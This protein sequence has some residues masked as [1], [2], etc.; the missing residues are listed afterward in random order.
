MIDDGAPAKTLKYGYRRGLVLGLTI[1]EMFLLI[2]FALLLALAAWS[3]E[4]KKRESIIQEA[5]AL[6]KLSTED[7]EKMLERAANAEQVERESE[8]LRIE[9]REFQNLRHSIEKIEDADDFLELVES[10]S[11]DSAVRASLQ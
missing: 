4:S 2:L 7:L 6:A 5:A 3:I 11:I 9:L 8:Q 1:A 10:A